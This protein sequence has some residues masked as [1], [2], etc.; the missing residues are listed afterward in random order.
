VT[1]LFDRISSISKKY[2]VFTKLTKGSEYQNKNPSDIDK[3]FY[4]YIKREAK[5]LFDED[6]KLTKMM[7]RLMN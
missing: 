5:L 1:L 4:E 3:K 7:K 2:E 6:D